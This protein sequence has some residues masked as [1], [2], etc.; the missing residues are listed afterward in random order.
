MYH[1][2]CGRTSPK[3]VDQFQYFVLNVGMNYK[4]FYHSTPTPI[5]I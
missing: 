1:A 3:K 5:F 4:V 2:A